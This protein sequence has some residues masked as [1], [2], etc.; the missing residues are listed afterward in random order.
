MR[1][2]MVLALVVAGMATTVVA[3]EGTL[4]HGPAPLA[5]PV[6]LTV[7]RRVKLSG[8]EQRERAVP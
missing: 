7:S 1:R 8:T 3:Q 4:R 5:D 6:A 2:F